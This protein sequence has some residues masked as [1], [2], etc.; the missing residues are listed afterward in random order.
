MRVW[1]GWDFTSDFI[2]DTDVVCQQPPEKHPANLEL[3]KEYELTAIMW[4]RGQRKDAEDNRKQIKED[5]R[6]K[7]SEGKRR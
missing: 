4:R 7:T 3:E 6:S 2:P 5:V 1:L